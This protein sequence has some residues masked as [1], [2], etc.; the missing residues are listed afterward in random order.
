[1]RKRKRKRRVVAAVIGLTMLAISTLAVTAYTTNRQNGETSAGADNGARRAFD[2]SNTPKSCYIPLDPGGLPLLES[3]RKLNTAPPTKPALSGGC[4]PEMDTQK[5]SYIVDAVAEIEARHERDRMVARLDGY[6][7]NRGSPMLGLGRY[8]YESTAR[9]GICPRLIV[10]IA[11]AESTCGK[12]CFAPYNYWGGLAYR[13]GFGSWEQSID[14]HVD[15][16]YRY[17][18]APQSA[19]DCPGYCVPNEPWMT[20]VERVRNSI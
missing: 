9:Y 5:W 2:V 12:A 11:E 17:Y 3:A 19:R 8:I 7:N 10:A 6:L 18:G 15:W 1:L 16:L 14:T 13:S 4:T 20:N